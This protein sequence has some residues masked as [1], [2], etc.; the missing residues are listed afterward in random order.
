MT[1]KHRSGG[2]G[3]NVGDEL[4]RVA[5]S[6]SNDAD[7]RADRRAV[8]GSGSTSAAVAKDST[9]TMVGVLGGSCRPDLEAAVSDEFIQKLLS[10][11]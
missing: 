11:R 8:V 5:H 2:R 10:G 9:R 6:M 1:P 4:L 7:A 3:G